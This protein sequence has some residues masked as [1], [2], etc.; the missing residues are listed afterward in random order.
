MPCSAP[1]SRSI[2]VAP[3]GRCLQL[4]RILCCFL[5]RCVNSYV[6]LLMLLCPANCRHL[7]VCR[8]AMINLWKIL[9]GHLP[10]VII[11]A[12]MRSGGTWASH[13]AHQVLPEQIPCL[14][15]A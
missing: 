10:D 2:T 1:L 9:Q 5:H 3:I 8:G 6:L 7:T 12:T 4:V 11:A 13:I 15:A 14:Q